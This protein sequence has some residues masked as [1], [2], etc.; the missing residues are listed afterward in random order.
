MIGLYDDFKL[1]E[2]KEYDFVKRFRFAPAFNLGNE[3]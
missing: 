1:G 2:V 3:G